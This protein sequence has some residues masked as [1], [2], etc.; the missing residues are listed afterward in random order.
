LVPSSMAIILTRSA[1]PT[2][3]SPPHR[4]SGCSSHQT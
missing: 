4:R 1:L 3:S 2:A